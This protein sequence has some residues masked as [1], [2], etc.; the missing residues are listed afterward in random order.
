MT[1]IVL[2]AKSTKHSQGDKYTYN[3]WYS[4]VRTAG[5]GF[6]LSMLMTSPLRPFMRNWRR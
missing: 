5:F 1:K 2:S 6:N 4:S 3:R